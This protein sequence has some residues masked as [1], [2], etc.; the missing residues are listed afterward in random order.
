[1]IA[2]SCLTEIDHVVSQWHPDWPFAYDEQLRKLMVVLAVQSQLTAYVWYMYVCVKEKER[3]RQAAARGRPVTCRK[4]VEVTLPD[5]STAVWRNADLSTEE[6]EEAEES[7]KQIFK[8]ALDLVIGSRPSASVRT[9][10]LPTPSQRHI[11]RSAVAADGLAALPLANKEETLLKT[12]LAG[13]LTLTS[14]INAMAHVDVP[15]AHY[16]YDGLLTPSE[17]T[18]RCCDVPISSP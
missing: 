7:A 14:R 12:L 1:M 4:P 2:K 6:A 15:T 3:E 18:P 17:A 16:D 11:R 8:A 13:R 5:R 10:F 9:A